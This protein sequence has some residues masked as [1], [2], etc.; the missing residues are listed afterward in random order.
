MDALTDLLDGPRA[1]GAFLL[2]TMLDPPWS[3][4]IADQAPVCLMALVRG[5][6]WVTYDGGEPVRMDAGDVAIARGTGGYVVADDPATPPQVLI[7]RDNSCTTLY[8]EPLMESM[9]LGVRTWGNSPAGRDILL[10]GTYQARVELT[11]RLLAALPPLLVLRDAEWDCALVPLLAEEIV[12]DDPGQGAVLD[13]ILDLL[14]IAV[15]RA[16]FSREEAESTGWFRAHA[17]PVV[18]PALELM[19]QNPAFP[20]TIA[21]LA[22]KVGVSRA[23]LS[24][25]FAKLLGEPPMTYLTGLRLAEAADL[26]RESDAT[27]ESVA[28]QVGYGTA[29]ALSAAFKR[30]RGVSPQEFRSRVPA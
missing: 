2:R 30:E 11:N 19:H 15:L 10:I 12:K 16:W 18:G 17:D 24:S 29:F 14:M 21:A 4:R 8:G 13:R 28:R 26:L 23:S 1:R 20:W 5:T 3:M 25:R 9:S 6:V 27:L 7:H 22:S